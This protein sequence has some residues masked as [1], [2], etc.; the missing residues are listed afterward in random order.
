M[1]NR[2]RRFL[3]KQDKKENDAYI[4]VEENEMDSE[5]KNRIYK[6]ENYA[7]SLTQELQRKYAIQFKE[8]GK[9]NLKIWVYRDIDG[10]EIKD[11]TFNRFFEKEYR[12]LVAINFDYEDNDDIFITYIELWYY[13]RGH[14]K[15]QGTLYDSSIYNLKREIEDLLNEL[16][17]DKDSFK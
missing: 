7:K 13:H 2:F 14:K 1:F 10:D 8:Q 4:T 9:S 6:L 16:L 3:T 17:A 15:G 12:S 5:L 11:I